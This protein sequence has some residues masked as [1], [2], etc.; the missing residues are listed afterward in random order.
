MIR[1]RS[2][3]GVIPENFLVGRKARAFNDAMPGGRDPYLESV[4]LRVPCDGC[5]EGRAAGSPDDFRHPACVAHMNS[6]GVR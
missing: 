1:A 4:N 2:G 6:E 5:R 3:N